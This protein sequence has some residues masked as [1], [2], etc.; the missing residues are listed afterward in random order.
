MYIYIY[1][2]VVYYF[3]CATNVNRKKKQAQNSDFC[4]CSN[5][6]NAPNMFF[7]K[8]STR[9]YKCIFRLYTPCSTVG[10]FLF[11]VLSIRE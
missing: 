3:P 4:G 5:H 1:L 6:A 8:I 9:D 11:L 2:E 7:E 10:S